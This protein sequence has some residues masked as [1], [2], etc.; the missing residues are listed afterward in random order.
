MLPEYDV[1]LRLLDEDGFY[2]YYAFETAR[3]LL[4]RKKP[5]RINILTNADLSSLMRLFPSNRLISNRENGIYTL[6][7]NQKVRFIIIDD[8]NLVRIP[9]LLHGRD[10]YLK[11][12]AKGLMFNVEAFFYDVER[13]KFYDP[14]NF[15][16]DLKEHIIK[17]VES[18]GVAI[19]N[20]P[21]L[22]LKTAKIFSETGFKIEKELVKVLDHSSDFEVYR[23]LNE[24]IIGDFMDILVSERAYEAF[25]LLDRWG[26]LERIIPELYELKD[27]AQDKEYHPEGDVFQHTIQCLKYVKKPNKN[28]MMA[29]LL[30]DIGK[31][32]AKSNGKNGNPFP[33]H[34]NLSKE[35]AR[36]VLKRF[37]FNSGD[38]K[39]ILF[40]VEN[41]MILDAVDILPDSRLK[42]IFESPY[43]SN[44]FEVYRADLSSGFH[45]LDRYY[46]ATRKYKEFL[47]KKRLREIGIYS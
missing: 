44:L 47:K 45:S 2:A 3:D 17:T 43:I 11:R 30:H 23:Y 10:S 35:I 1:F 9:G 27:I 31:A 41:H 40:L 32:R 14:L 24:D 6:E 20:N 22:G 25:L 46:R 37:N 15:Y 7:D 16:R 38:R 26:I 42:S 4:L 21:L 34:S 39:E 13:E 28:L 8:Q 33:N 36:D 12:I 5:S 19:R 18:P 29:L